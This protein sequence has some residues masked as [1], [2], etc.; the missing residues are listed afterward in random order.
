MKTFVIKVKATKDAFVVT[1]T[2]ERMFVSN[3]L[4]LVGNIEKAKTFD[5]KED[6]LKFANEMENKFNVKYDV[7]TKD[8]MKCPLCGKSP[9][10]CN[11]DK[12]MK[13]KD[14]IK[15]LNSLIADEQEAIDEYQK[16]IDKFANDKSLLYMSRD[17]EKIIDDEKEHIRILEKLKSQFNR[18]Q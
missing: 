11:D 3:D 8:S 12:Q 15:E 6:A 13:Q 18:E 7:L 14:V 5:R 4:N 9:C 16:A 10:E 2:K 1:N 17:F